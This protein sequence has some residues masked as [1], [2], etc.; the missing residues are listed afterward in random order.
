[1]GEANRI[2]AEAT[3]WLGTPY[4]H[5]ARIM[6]A[7]VDCAQLLYGVFVEG[8]GLVPEFEIDAYP[9]DWM[10]HRSEERFV[11][12]VLNRA[13]LVDA[14]QA[15]DIALFKWGRCFAHGAIVVNWPTVIHADINAGRVSMDDADQGRFAGREVKFFR[16]KEAL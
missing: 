15:G 6:G 16:V 7:G 11:S 3:K 14:P 2:V 12:Y 13:E 8:L 10:M 5:H 9:A 1:M 4:H